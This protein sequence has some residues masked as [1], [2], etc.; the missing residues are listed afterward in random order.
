MKFACFYGRQ[1][2]ANIPF[3]RHIF[4]EFFL[5]ISVGLSGPVQ[6]AFELKNGIAYSK[7]SGACA[8][9]NGN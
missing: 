4:F 1:M 5:D 2:L 9:A 7:K 6:T 3:Q 8:C